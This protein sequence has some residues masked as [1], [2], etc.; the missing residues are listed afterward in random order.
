MHPRLSSIFSTFLR[1]KPATKR[2]PIRLPI[3]FARV[4]SSF[5]DE[6]RR[7]SSRFTCAWGLWKRSAVVRPYVVPSKTT[8][9]VDAMTPIKTASSIGTLS[10]YSLYNTGFLDETLSAL[11]S[12]LAAEAA[13]KSP[14]SQCSRRTKGFPRHTT[15]SIRDAIRNPTSGG[16]KSRP[17]SPPL[18][19]PASA[20]TTRTAPNISDNP[21]ETCE[22]NTLIILPSFSR[23]RDKIASSI[24]LTPAHLL[25]KRQRTL[26]SN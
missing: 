10:L 1:K 7:R 8:E 16:T 6:K 11:P 12:P 26:L 21:E 13:A 4:R 20:H 19:V 25:P 2:G 5:Y 23:K 15:E 18:L 14:T 22:E 3:S 17:L 24:Q 9:A